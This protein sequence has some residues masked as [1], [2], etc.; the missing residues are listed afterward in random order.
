LSFFLGTFSKRP[1]FPPRLSSDCSAARQQA[2]ISFRR[3]V[4]NFPPVVQWWSTPS[5][6]GLTGHSVIEGAPVFLSFGG[7]SSLFPLRGKFL[8]PCFFETPIARFSHLPP[9]VA[10]YPK[11]SLHSPFPL[12]RS[13]L[14]FPLLKVRRVFPFFCFIA[15]RRPPTSFFFLN[16]LASFTF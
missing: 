12:S 5:T 14:V 1:P 11:A 10:L 8:L 3:F 4:P 7:P 13:P 2:S 16:I 6:D 15:P 9:S